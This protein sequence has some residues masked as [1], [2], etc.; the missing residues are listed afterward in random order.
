MNKDQI[1]GK[2]EQ[3]KGE[4]KKIWGKLT[5]D[6]IMLYNGKQDLF[7]GKMKEKYG[8]AKEAVELRIKEFEKDCPSCSDAGKPTKIA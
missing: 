3:L 8:L 2:F 5:D 4:I 6:E 1:D 7:F